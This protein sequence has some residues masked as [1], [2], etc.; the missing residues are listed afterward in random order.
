MSGQA[1]KVVGHM[2]QQVRQVALHGYNIRVP[3]SL[4]VGLDSLRVVPAET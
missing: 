3:K 4:Q 1:L 2:L